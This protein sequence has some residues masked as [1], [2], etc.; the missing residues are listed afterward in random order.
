MKY[1]NVSIHDVT[2]SSLSQV[3]RISDLLTELNI[4]KPTYLVIPKYHGEDDIIPYANDLKNIIGNNEI[5]MHGYTHKGKKHWLLSYMKLFTDGEGEFISASEL[6]IRIVLGLDILKKAEL[7]PKGFVPPA[8][9]IDKDNIKL[10][11]D[12]FFTFLNTRSYIYDLKNGKRYKAPVLTFSSRRILKTLSIHA[13]KATSF[14]FR[15]HN[16]IRI[17]I[18]PKDID[19]SKKIRLIKD[20]LKNMKNKREEIYF[21]EF[22]NGVNIIENM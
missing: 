11:W 8:W 19:S 1:F 10:F 12:S 7:N 15:K 2:S 22:I 5:A 18:H 3:K 6:R 21:S 16:M 13:F 20:I 17:A 14:M 9:L 4:K